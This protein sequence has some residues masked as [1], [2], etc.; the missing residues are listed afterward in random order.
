MSGDVSNSDSRLYKASLNCAG[1]SFMANS[2]STPHLPIAIPRITEKIAETPKSLLDFHSPLIPSNRSILVRYPK[3]LDRQWG[4]PCNQ[5]CYAY[6]EVLAMS[7][8]NCD[9][10]RYRFFQENLHNDLA[11]V[12][13]MRKLEIDGVHM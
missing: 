1:P 9:R 6:L 3:L 7:V 2:S 5:A 4:I 10:K 8:L 13:E 11:S 12:G